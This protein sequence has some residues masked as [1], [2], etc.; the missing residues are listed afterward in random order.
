MEAVANIDTSG[1][2]PALRETHFMVACDVANP[3]YG[4]DG[5]AYIFAQQKG[6]DSNM[7][8]RLDEGM[9]SLAEVIKKTTGKDITNYPGAGAAGGMGGGLLA[10]FNAELKPGTE[11]L[12]KAI[13][14]SEKIKGADLIITGEGKADPMPAAR[15]RAR[16]GS[17]CRPPA[18]A[19]YPVPGG[20]CRHSRSPCVPD[21]R[22]TS[23]RRKRGRS[24]DP[25]RRARG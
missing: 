10:F 4:P 8:Q 15:W 9:Q 16:R 19:R 3:F 7:V 25:H 21:R 12:L 6:A 13:D 11:L 5:A 22:E 20:R 14:F 1:I 23:L 24:P 2:H 18:P 17:A